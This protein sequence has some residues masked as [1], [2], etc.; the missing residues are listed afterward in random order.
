M[1][2]IFKSRKGIA[3][4]IAILLALVLLVPVG[5]ALADRASVHVVNVPEEDRFDPFALVIKAGDQ[6][7]WVNNDEEDHAIVSDD[8]FTTTNH[9]GEDILLPGT[10]SSGGNPGEVTLRFRK[11]G[12]FV[13]YCRFHAQ[14]DEA[15]QPIAPGPDG[16][17]Q[18]AN[19][20]FGTPM[21]GVIVVLAAH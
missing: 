11:V 8:F 2:R 15:H 1:S 16:G 13:Y 4:F 5:G 19:G 6:V 18:D 20:N 3:V 7:R 10:E 21:S 9:K 14:L 17:I 12:V